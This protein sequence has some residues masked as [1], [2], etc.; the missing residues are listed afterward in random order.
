MG[1]KEWGI[2]I[3]TIGIGSGEAFTTI[4]T[5]LGKYKLPAGQNL[6]ERLLQAIAE[7][8][9]GFYGRAGDAEALKKIVEKIDQLEKTNVKSIQYTQYAER[10]GVWA[11][12]A[13]LMLGFEI[14]A[15]CGVFR[16]IPW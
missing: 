3:Y 5:P 14:L 6:D 9:G 11:M 7:N 12:A 10:F 2:I 1:P 13:M 15:G 8:T 4:N 16:K